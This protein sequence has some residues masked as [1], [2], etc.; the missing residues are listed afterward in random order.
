MTE[1]HAI[2]RVRHALRM[3]RLQV[4][5]VRQL[6]PHM[7][8]VTLVG[9]DLDGFV[10]AAPDDHVKLFFP[11][12]DGALNLPTLGPEGPVYPEGVEPSASRDYTPRRYDAAAG[13]LDIDFVLHGEGPA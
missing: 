8:R 11:V 3:R 9:P 4:S 2:V 7:V 10:S 12:A 6:T 5:R 13:E 1:R